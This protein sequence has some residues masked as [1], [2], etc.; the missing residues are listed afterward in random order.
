MT[1]EGG[2]WNSGWKWGGWQ[3]A[4]WEMHGVLK[5]RTRLYQEVKTILIHLHRGALC[6]PSHRN[7][8]TQWVKRSIPRRKQKIEHLRSQVCSLIHSSIPSFF[9]S[10]C[11]SYLILCTEEDT[12][13]TKCPNIL[14]E[15]ELIGGTISKC[16]KLC[17]CMLSRFSHVWCFATPWTPSGSSVQGILQARILE[18]VARPSSRG[19]S[20]LTDWTC[21]SYLLYLCCQI[22]SLPPVPPG[23]PMCKSK[24]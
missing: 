6:T 20:R 16:I 24:S 13:G 4:T 15:L 5:I 12:M 1:L 18:W 14:K 17:A 19:S 2:D 23:K 9:Q 21:V 8:H 10:L 7:T 3:A 22:D 11:N